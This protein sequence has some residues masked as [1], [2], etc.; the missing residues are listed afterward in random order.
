VSTLIERLGAALGE[1]GLIADQGEMAPFVTDFRGRMSGVADAVALPSSTDEAAAVVAIAREHN[2]AI[3]PLGGNTGLCYAAVPT[4]ARGR[5]AVVVGMGRMANLRAMDRAANVVTVDAGMTLARVHELAAG[6]D[7]QFPLHLGSEGTAQIGGLISTNA[8]GTGVLRY[9]PMRDL[10][11]GIEAVLPDGSVYRDLD[12][13]RKNNTGYDLKHLLIGAEGTLGLVTGAAL[14][15]RQPNRSFAHGW[16]SVTGPEAAVELLSRLQ[17]R[18][19]DAVEAFEMLNR[20]EVDCVLRH[21]PRTRLPFEATPTWSVMIELAHTD[22]DADLVAALEEVMAAALEAGLAD[23]AIVAQNEAQ[24]NDIWHIRHSVTEAHKIEG[25]GIVHDTA[26]RNSAVPDFIAAADEM[27][28]RLF[29]QARVL[30]V[31]HL[32]DGNVH[33]ILMFP[34]DY[35]RALPDGEAKALEV[36]MAVHDIAM[37]FGGT[38][39]AEHGIGRKLTSELQRLGDPVKLAVMRQIKQALDP[40]GMMNPGALLG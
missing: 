2:A 17:D 38:I 7:R 12:A 33:Y 24:A 31:S 13:L 29:P 21:I 8:G 10:V 28:A 27:S 22:P 9:G 20:A 37:R 6:E 36:E 19:G 5:P 14:R 35:W 1:R 39:S 25:V 16:I 40:D 32:G 26:V 34:H 15:L 4:A 30:V 11:C 23:D 3:F 18:C